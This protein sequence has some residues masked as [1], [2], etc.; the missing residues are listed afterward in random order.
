MGGGNRGHWDGGCYLAPH[1]DMG[2]PKLPH[3]RSI[4]D[5]SVWTRHGIVKIQ[6]I[7]PAGTLLSLPTLQMTFQL[8]SWMLVRYLQLKHVVQAQSPSLVAITPHVVERFL[9][10]RN[11]DGIL[12]S[13]YICITCGV[14][15]IYILSCSAPGRKT[16]LACQKRSGTRV[17]SNI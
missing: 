14:T 15:N 2:N 9:T 7:M 11:T 3:L 16:F 13:I 10:T 1:T 8:P 6:Q 17:Y 4:P 12:S 5:A